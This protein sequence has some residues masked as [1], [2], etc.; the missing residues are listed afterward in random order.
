[1]IFAFLEKTENGKNGAGLDNLLITCHMANKAS[2]S[3]WVAT[4]YSRQT[5]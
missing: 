5:S 4:N 3:Q 2:P 1:M